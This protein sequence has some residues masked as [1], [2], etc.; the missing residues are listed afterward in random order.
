MPDHTLNS[1]KGKLPA[2]L[3]LQEKLAVSCLLLLL[4]TFAACSFASKH[5]KCAKIEKTIHITCL[6]ACVGQNE[7]ELAS[8]VQVSDLLARVKL[9]PEADISKLVL[10]QRLKSEGHFIIPTKGKMTVFISGAVKQPGIIY[11]PEGLRFNQ[12]KEYLALA[13]DADIGVFHRRR[14]LLCEGETIHIPAKTEHFV[15]K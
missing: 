10:E 13:D 6:G 14:R 8:G 5:Q 4:S 11:L 1:D 3:C 12:L 9:T 15:R 2:C 7:L